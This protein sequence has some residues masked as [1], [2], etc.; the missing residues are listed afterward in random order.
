MPIETTP[1]PEIA[2]KPHAFVEYGGHGHETE[3]VFTMQKNKY[4]EARTL[5]FELEDRIIELLGDGW[6]VMNRGERIEITPPNNSRTPE[7]DTKLSNVIKM[8][9]GDDVVFSGIKG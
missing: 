7:T 1:N 5:S 2:R 6:S 9:M 8:I 4:S 3:Y